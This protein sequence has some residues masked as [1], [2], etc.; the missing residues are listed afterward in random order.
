MLLVRAAPAGARLRVYRTATIETRG[1]AVSSI[2]SWMSKVKL[3]V[4]AFVLRHPVHGPI[5]FDTGL[6]PV[7]ETE[8]KKKMGRLNYWLVPF[9][10]KPG[11]N[12]AAQMKRDGIAPELVKWVVI[13]HLHLDH[14]GMIDAFPNAT[15]VVDKREW[16]HWKNLKESDRRKADLNP[17]E[18]E[19][20]IAKL[21]LVDLSGAP[22]FGPFDH[23]LDLLGDGSAMVV[24]LSGHTAGSVGLWLNLAEG[25]VLLA[26]DASWILD[27]HEDLALPIKG[28]IFDLDDYW[29]RLYQLR[30]AQEAAPRLVIFPGHDL[31]PLKLRPRADVELVPF[32]R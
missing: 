12:L 13:S 7:M 16:E 31:A 18:L 30:D 27:N 28:H 8:P 1:G 11:Q 32:P 6:D 3:D 15:V 19:P 4:P 21:K 29:R 14:A 26:G 9:D 22:A 5:V 2:K 23:A 17:A 25:P 10:V 24:D 20:K